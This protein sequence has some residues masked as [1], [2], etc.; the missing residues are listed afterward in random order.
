MNQYCTLVQSWVKAG[1]DLFGPCEEKQQQH[2]AVVVVLHELTACIQQGAAS[3]SWNKAAMQ[4]NVMAAVL[5][6]LRLWDPQP[7]NMLTDYR[8]QI[9]HEADGFC[10]LKTETQQTNKQSNTRQ[11]SVTWLDHLLQMDLFTCW[12]SCW[13]ELRQ[14]GFSLK[15]Q[16]FC[17]WSRV[18]LKMENM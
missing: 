4:I 9:K 11:L 14:W 5:L 6:R 17:W 13:R 18:M 16:N 7:V 2:W 3:A 15:G 8:L 10:S 12:S 1:K